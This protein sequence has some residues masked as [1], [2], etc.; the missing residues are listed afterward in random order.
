L[1][2]EAVRMLFLASEIVPR[3]LLNEPWSPAAPCRNR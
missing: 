1:K 3:W 2:E